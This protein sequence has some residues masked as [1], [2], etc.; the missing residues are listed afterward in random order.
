MHNLLYKVC[1]QQQAQVF[2]SDTHK[3]RLEEA[4]EK[5]EVRYELIGL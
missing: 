3:K 5:L 2:I 1:I 4:F